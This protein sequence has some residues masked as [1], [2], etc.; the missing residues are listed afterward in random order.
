MS[1]KLKVPELNNVA[2]KELSLGNHERSRT[3]P[4]WGNN[5][6]E[7]NIILLIYILYASG[8]SVASVLF[9]SS[10]STIAIPL[11]AKIM[12]N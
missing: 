9:L 3:K 12:L 1:I 2:I 11:L 4:R 8:K 10:V 5:L 6:R 7:V